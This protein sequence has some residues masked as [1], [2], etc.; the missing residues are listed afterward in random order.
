MGRSYGGGV[1][2]LEPNEAEMLPLPLVG[3]ELLNLN[4]LDRLLREGNIQAVL[5]ITDNVLLKDGL[6]LSDQETRMLRTIWQKLRD[7]RINRKPV[8]SLKM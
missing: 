8:G 1:L 4:E 6:G 3:A 2:E 7:R 5:D